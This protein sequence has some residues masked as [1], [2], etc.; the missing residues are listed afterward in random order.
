MVLGKQEWMKEGLWPDWSGRRS[1]EM[2]NTE[3]F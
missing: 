2:G 3:N 1:R